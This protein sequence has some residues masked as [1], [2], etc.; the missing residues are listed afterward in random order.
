VEADFGLA[1]GPKILTKKDASNESK[2][3]FLF[4]LPS[5]PEPEL[6]IKKLRYPV[7]T[8]NKAKLIERY[9]YLFVLI[10]KHGTYIDG[11]AGPQDPEKP[12]TWAAKLVLENEPRWFRHFYLFDKDTKQF[13]W[14]QRLKA[15]Q[16]P[17]TTNEPKR[18]I[19]VAKGD[20][21]DLADKLLDSG[22]ISQKEATFCLLD[23]RTFECK[24]ETVK[25]LAEYKSSGNKIELFYFLPN[26]W[27]NRALK[28]QKQESVV[29]QWW[30]SDDW[31]KLKNLSQ[32]KRADLF[33]KRFKEELGYRS[34]KQWPIYER[35]DNST[36]MYYMIHATDHPEA[37]TL[38]RRAY[39]KAVH[40][41]E[42]A[43]QLS[44]ELGA[45]GTPVK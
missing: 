20:F 4:E 5:R 40:R 26:L 1:A 11:F 16:Q 3:P 10:T 27:L 12:E 42:P 34:A 7:W 33:K 9:L 32:N 15:S 41:K 35:Q 18:E 8:A 31:H 17:R 36:V 43:D 2:E 37:P 29:A 25:A 39:E 13:T 28:A 38:M 21:N 22:V 6:K 45:R 19:E 30:G 14:L 23:Q 24:W 44:L